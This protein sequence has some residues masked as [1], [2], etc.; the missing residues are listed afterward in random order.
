[1]EDNSV[2]SI[3]NERAWYVVA[4]Y[5]GM[6]YAV[7]RNLEQRIISMNME[8]YIFRVLIPEVKHTEK[9]KNGETREI[10]EKVYPGYVFVDMIVTDESWFIVRNTQMVTGIL[11][12]S[13]GA[14][15]PVPLTNEEIKPILK[16]CGVTLDLHVNYNV[17]D[18][19]KIN[20]GTFAGQTAVVDS[21]DTEKEQVNVLVDCFGR[22][23]IQEL[24]ID[25]V[26]K[27][28]ED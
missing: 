12:S 1:M 14:A 26:E 13:G 4:T 3:Q 16:M 10:S 9:K 18:T 2:K 24:G 5:S 23:T 6:E 20:M 17:G 25:Q 7:K 28:V 8:K 15:K 11:G 27:Y 21:I 19:V 22:Q